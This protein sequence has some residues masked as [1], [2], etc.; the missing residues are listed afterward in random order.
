M[1]L[2]EDIYSDLTETSN[3]RELII[4]DYKDTYSDLLQAF[5]DRTAK[6]S[7]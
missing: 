1:H 5:N 6:I 3:V 2:I 4:K 7:Y